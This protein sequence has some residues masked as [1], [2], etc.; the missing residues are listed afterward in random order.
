MSTVAILVARRRVCL[1]TRGKHECGLCLALI[2][3]IRMSTYES[4][5]AA[6]DCKVIFERCLFLR[7]G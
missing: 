3:I 7:L 2:C 5:R 6:R 1:E 4:T